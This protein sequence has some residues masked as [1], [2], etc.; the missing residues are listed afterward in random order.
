MNMIVL[1]D[2]DR[3]FMVVSMSA[4]D[5]DGIDSVVDVMMEVSMDGNVDDDDAA[6]TSLVENKCNLDDENDDGDK[7]TLADDWKVVLEGIDV[8]KDCTKLSC[9]SIQHDVARRM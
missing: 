2:A 3:P 8:V 7:C 9:T 5:D 6:S 4:V 1:V